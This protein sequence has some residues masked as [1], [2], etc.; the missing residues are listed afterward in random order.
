M[1]A[2]LFLFLF[3][4]FFL[5]L[6]TLLGC[7]KSVVEPKPEIDHYK[8][9]IAFTTD[10]DGNYEIYIMDSNGSNPINLTNYKSQ[11]ENPVFQPQ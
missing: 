4:I 6:C 1:K 3:I 10:R 9:K 8:G 2:N 5:I 11:D 7:K